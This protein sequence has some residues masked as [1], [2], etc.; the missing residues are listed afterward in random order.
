[1]K[2]EILLDNFSTLIQKS[3]DIKKIK[4]MILELAVQG[5]FVPQ[6]SN[7]EPASELLKKVQA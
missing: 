2:L 6:D 4:S 5:K 1:M 3:S 7:D